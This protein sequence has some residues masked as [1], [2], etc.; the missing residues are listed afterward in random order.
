LRLNCA[1]EFKRAVQSLIRETETIDARNDSIRI[2]CKRDSQKQPL[3]SERNIA[4]KE[5]VVSLYL[6]ACHG[7]R[8]REMKVKRGQRVLSPT[9]LLIGQY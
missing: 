7:H 1:R 2:V 5:V 4:G 6:G 9:S 3:L 8:N